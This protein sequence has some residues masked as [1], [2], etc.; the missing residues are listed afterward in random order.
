MITQEDIKSSRETSAYKAFCK[1]LFYGYRVG[2]YLN[3]LFTDATSLWQQFIGQY[4]NIT[5]S[6]DAK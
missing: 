2:R 6:K 5:R 3:P 1:G 4:R